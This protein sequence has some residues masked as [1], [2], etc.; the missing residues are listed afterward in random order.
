MDANN[1]TEDKKCLFLFAEKNKWNVKDCLKPINPIYNGVGWYI[2]KK[3]RDFVEQISH[4]LQMKLVEWPLNGETFEELRRRN[5]YEFLSEKAIKTSLR[6]DALKSSLEI[7]TLDNEELIQGSMKERLEQ[8]S[9]GKQLLECLKEYDH[10]QEQIECAEN[11]EKLSKLNPNILPIIPISERIKSQNAMLDKYRGKKY[12]G[13]CVKTINEFN[14]KMLGLR[15]LILLAAA[16]NVGKTALTIQLACEMLLTELDA[17][18]VYVSLEMDVE[19]IFTRINLYLSELSFDTYV[20]GSRKASGENG[21]ENFFS[22]E[23]LKKIEKATKE[24]KHIGDRLQI[25]D[26]ASCNCFSAEIIMDYVQR[27]KIKTGSTRAIVVIDYLQVWPSPS[28]FRFTSDIEADKWRIGEIKKIRDS[29]NV[30]NQ[31]PVIVVSE[32]RKPSEGGNIW[33]GD[34]ADV[35]G[36]ARGTYTPDAVWL[37][38][39]LSEQQL[40]SLW[41]KMKISTIT[42]HGDANDFED[43]K[44]DH[45]IKNFLA[46]HGITICSLKMLK[47]RDGMKKFN[48]LLAFHFHKNKFEKINWLEIQ[49]L[50]K[51]NKQ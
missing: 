27:L 13:L 24:I 26:K 40:K 29:L 2:E 9:D 23:E 50:A 18:L 35:M 37:L 42:H 41:E 4:A 22:Q 28:N 8:T 1:K 39:P 25:I 12:L 33:A 34:L 32:A 20:L 31:D 51:S 30:V 21:Y 36:S 11:I 46:F 19:E 3:H 15:K 44:N 49:A 10:L 5:R 43:T 6:I 45:N 17:C 14:D 16:P 48:I 7:S 47:G 38:N